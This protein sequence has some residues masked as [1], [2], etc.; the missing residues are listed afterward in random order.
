[1]HTRRFI[2]A[3]PKV[4]SATA[5]LVLVGICASILPIPLGRV[6]PD[7]KDLSQPFPCQHC[8]CGCKSAEQC[9]KNCCCFSPTEKAAWA[10]KNGVTPPSYAVL[11]DENRLAEN[12]KASNKECSKGC[13]SKKGI[14]SKEP[15][16]TE[17]VM[18]LSIM[19]YQCSGQSSVFCL[20]PWAIIETQPDMAQRWELD[21][22]Q[23]PDESLNPIRVF[24][25]P[26]VPP[27]RTLG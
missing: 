22:R 20:L 27:P 26:D 12:G 17:A 2:F 24:S 7:S 4:R 16:S 23:L 25:I 18:V 10:K 9:W 19:A 14:V 21:S 8:A 11:K 5:L 1:M 6:L 15:A 3:N 13:C